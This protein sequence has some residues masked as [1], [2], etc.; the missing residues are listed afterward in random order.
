[1]ACVDYYE[2]IPANNTHNILM[3][4]PIAEL[5]SNCLF[6]EGI[7]T[8]G[9]VGGSGKTCDEA[10]LLILVNHELRSIQF[11]ES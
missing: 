11:E 7:E 5:E 8:K 2:P 3:E 4:A 1:M 9:V 6:V 10:L